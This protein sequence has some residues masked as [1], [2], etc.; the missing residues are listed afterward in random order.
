MH[1]HALARN[2]E[3]LASLMAET[4]VNADFRRKLY[5]RVI[6]LKGH[7]VSELQS[8][9][10]QYAALDA[11]SRLPGLPAEVL[12]NAMKGIPLVQRITQLADKLAAD[13]KAAAGADAASIAK[14]DAAAAAIESAKAAGGKGKKAAVVDAQV[15]GEE[16]DEVYD[17]AE[18]EEEDGEEEAGNGLA[19]SAALAALS[20]RLVAI[21]R[22]AFTPLATSSPSPKTSTSTSSGLAGPRVGFDRMMAS[23]DAAS[24][25]YARAAVPILLSDVTA[26]EAVAYPPVDPCNSRDV[27]AFEAAAT[28]S[29]AADLTGKGSTV[30]AASSSTS[31][32]SAT[33]PVVSPAVVDAAHALRY[34]ADAVFAEH[35]TVPLSADSS[36]ASAS[37]KAPAGSIKQRGQAAP[38]GAASAGR[39][40]TIAEWVSRAVAATSSTSTSS[41]SE[42]MTRR[43]N[44]IAMPLQVNHCCM[45]FRTVEAT[46]PDAAA[47][48]VLGQLMTDGF[49]HRE[50]REKGGAYGGESLASGTASSLACCVRCAACPVSFTCSSH[51]PSVFPV[52]PPCPPARR[53]CALRL[54]RRL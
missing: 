17:E 46:H 18:E 44:Y 8:S 42:R 41:P 28:S 9:P 48:A 12:S 11:T 36:S 54:W 39:G 19:S 40:N 49:L 3:K 37:G 34:M 16:T 47:L 43:C 20:G 13:A 6:Q 51:L 50:I 10:L 24:L 7:L 33:S 1:G 21:T 32:A 5:D 30:K 26:S 29:L 2:A 15:V 52:S 38:S 53:R 23:F 4:A 22:A 35:F 14:A 45:A 25:P 31:A 27:E